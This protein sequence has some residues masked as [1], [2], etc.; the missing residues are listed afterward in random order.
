MPSKNI[1]NRREAYRRWAEK[2]IEKRRSYQRVLAVAKKANPIVNECSVE[3]CFNL[4]ERHHPDYSKPEEIVWFCKTHHRRLNHAGKCKICGDKIRARGWCNK[5]YISERKK[6]DPEYARL[7][8][9]ASIR[10][11]HLAH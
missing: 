5:H 8:L 2:N 7:R 9:E 3:G 10:G 1:E 11:K 4:G 6:V